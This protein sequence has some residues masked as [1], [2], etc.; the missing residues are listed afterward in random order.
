MG[1]RQESTFSVGDRPGEELARGS[2]AEPGARREGPGE[3]GGEADPRQEPWVAILEA[4]PRAP[5]SALQIRKDT[6]RS[7][8]GILALL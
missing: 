7:F 5:P 4:R 1:N 3:R 2:A 8:L 6:P